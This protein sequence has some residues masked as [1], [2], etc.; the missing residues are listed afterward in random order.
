ML[1][2]D[3]YYVVNNHYQP[4]RV[5]ATIGFDFLQMPLANPFLL[6]KVVTIVN[7]IRFGK[8]EVD[9]ESETDGVVH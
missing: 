6:A 4:S 5:H 8:H 2:A 7:E 3:S 1:V 9:V